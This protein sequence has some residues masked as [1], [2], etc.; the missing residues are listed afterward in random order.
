MA[1][2]VVLFKGIVEKAMTSLPRPHGLAYIS[3]RKKLVAEAEKIVHLFS[4][5]LQKQTFTFFGSEFPKVGFAK[6]WGFSRE[7][8]VVCELMKS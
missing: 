5:I 2:N 1:R 4:E 6:P 7:L 3:K 8:Q